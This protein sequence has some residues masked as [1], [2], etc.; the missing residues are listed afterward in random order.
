MID[1]QLAIQVLTLVLDNSCDVCRFSTY[2]IYVYSV[3]LLVDIGLFKYVGNI[4]LY[5]Y[6]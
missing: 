5:T 2:C 3:C 1:R 4:C 6:I